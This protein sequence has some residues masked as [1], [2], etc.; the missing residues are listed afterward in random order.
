MQ[1]FNTNNSTIKY[2]AQLTNELRMWNRHF[3]EDLH[4]AKQRRERC[5]TT[6]NGREMHTRVTYCFT[7]VKVP[8]S[9][10]TEKQTRNNKIS[11][12]YGEIECWGLVNGSALNSAVILQSIVIVLENFKHGILHLIRNMTQ[13]FKFWHVHKGPENRDLSKSVH[14]RNRLNN[15]C[16]IFL[17]VKIPAP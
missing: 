11:H 17:Y 8:Y 3:S 12:R 2:T 9:T 7:P 13:G 4:K 14:S 1:H 10:I 6:V 15:K 16:K 5:W